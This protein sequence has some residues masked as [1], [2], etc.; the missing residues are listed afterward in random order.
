MSEMLEKLYKSRQEAI[1]KVNALN[2]QVIRINSHL[3]QI[4]GQINRII[5]A[6]LGGDGY[7]KPEQIITERHLRTGAFVPKNPVIKKKIIGLILIFDSINSDVTPQLIMSKLAEDKWKNVQIAS[8]GA[9][10]QFMS[11]YPHFRRV[12]HGVY[13]IVPEAREAIFATM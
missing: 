13:E 2:D 1:T 11:D 4:D 10:Y 3:T 5:M 12:G 8:K 9:L 7:K 6:S